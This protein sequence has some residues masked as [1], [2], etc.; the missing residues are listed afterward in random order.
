MDQPP[1]DTSTSADRKSRLPPGAAVNEY[2]ERWPPP[3]G[4]LPKPNLMDRFFD[5]L[6]TL[7]KR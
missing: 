1:T 6:G 7:R 4:K 3:D 2:G 5:W